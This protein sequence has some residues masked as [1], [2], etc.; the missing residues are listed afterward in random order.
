MIVGHNKDVGLSFYNDK[1]KEIM[2]S[3]IMEEPFTY[4]PIVAGHM[5]LVGGNA[6]VFGKITEGYDIINPNVNIEISYE[7]VSGNPSR[8]NI[9]TQ[10]YERAYGDIPTPDTRGQYY[11]IVDGYAFIQLPEIVIEGSYFYITVVNPKLT[12]T[13]NVTAWYLVKHGDKTIDVKNGLIASLEA[14]GISSNKIDSNIPNINLSLIV[15]NKIYFFPDYKL[16]MLH[17]VKEIIS[18][19]RVYENYTF[20]IYILTVGDEIIFPQL[21]CGATHGFGIV[22]KDRAGR[23]CSV[24]KTKEMDVYLPFYSEKVP[25]DDNLF[26]SIIKLVFKISNKPPAWAESYEIV[27]FGNLTMDYFLQIREDNIITIPNT[28]GNRFAMDISSTLDWIYTKN[29]RWKVP[30]YVWQAGDRV[31]LIGAINEDTGIVSKPLYYGTAIGA[32]FVYDYEIEEAGNMYGDVFGGVEAA[33][34]YLIFQAVNHPTDFGN[35]L[36]AVNISGDITGS[37]THE[38][39][40]VIG[41]S[42]VARVDVVTLAGTSGSLDISLGGIK[43]TVT[44]ITD[45]IAAALAFFQAYADDYLTVGIIL[46]QGSGADTPIAHTTNDLVFTSSV[47][48]VEFPGQHNILVEIYRPRKGLMINVAYGTGLVFEILTDANGNKYHKGDVD[49]DFDISGNLITPASV[50]NFTT[51]GYSKAADC[52]KFQRLNYKYKTGSVEPFWAESIFPSD[53]WGGQIISNKLTSMG[54]P[55][56][57]DLSLKQTILNER[58]R[59]G[60]FLITGTR[61]NNIAHF[62]Y[63]DFRDLQTVDG[64]IVGLK[65]VGYTL[66]V[67]QKYK[68]TSIYINRIQTFNP[69]GTE[70]FTLTDRFLGTM[71]PMEDDWGCQHP[72]AIMVNGRNIYY[73]DNS[74]GM[75]IRS[76]P[77]GQQAL[78]GPEYKMSRYFKDILGWINLNGGSSALE[79]RIGANNEFREIWITW[80]MNG[81]VKGII[82]SEKNQRFIT[83]IDQITESYIHLG[84]FF[85]HL[86]QQELW[87]MNTDEG[88]NYLSWVGVPAYAEFTIVGNNEPLK[89]KVFNAI[90]LFADHLMNS[91]AKYIWIPNVASAV[92]QIME[93]NIPIW[94][95]REGV[96]YGEILRDENSPGSYVSV[97]ASKMNGRV[98]RGRYCFVRLNTT[99]HTDKVRVTSVIVIS[100]L[101]ERNP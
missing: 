33:G 78:S 74:Q 28:N 13:L 65:D 71:R 19:E 40:N 69:D 7:D 45:V 86:Y 5:E 72:D 35:D 34:D 11:R 15:Y 39:A 98:M 2:D 1:V 58:I 77:N 25:N 9:T 67:I 73:W 3:S 59:N 37:I 17:P 99:E 81:E 63:N 53:W 92:N 94:Q 47:A 84:N 70:Q 36:K 51:E 49:Q 64:S 48:G 32:G 50:N 38:Q 100:T 79:V 42:P 43:R 29:N 20:D 23:T 4:I 97:I 31:R 27:Y 85:A 83:R 54:F 93:T 18:I 88:Q 95:K 52:W 46:T 80:R 89:N 56:L 82:F 68:E 44:I 55:F 75:F 16:F 91:L 24:V 14:N 8:T 6:V 60:G 12:P 57:E 41:T 30:P 101:S 87:I 21:K 96:Y 66:K 62:V 10:F 26:S 90:A 22:Y 61:T 76:A